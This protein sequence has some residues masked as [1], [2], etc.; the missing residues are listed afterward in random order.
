MIGGYIFDNAV[1]PA[2]ASAESGIP[3]AKIVEAFEL[4]EGMLVIS[5]PD[6]AI[7]DPLGDALPAQVVRGA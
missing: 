1:P 6:H 3:V 5:L 7:V 4:V 2:T